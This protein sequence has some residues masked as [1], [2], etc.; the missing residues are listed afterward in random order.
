VAGRL[1]LPAASVLVVA[2][3]L[4][5]ACGGGSD[6]TTS[7]AAA[8]NFAPLASLGPLEPAPP[9]GKL[10]G[11]LV[12]I[13]NAP[14]LAPAASEAT[15]DKSVDGIK[16]EQNARLVFHVHTHITV[17]VDGKPRR[18]PAG[19]GIYPPI[20]P[21]NYRG[22]QFGLTAE[23]CITWLSTRYPDGLIHVESSEQRSF[24]LGD[25][26]KVWGQPL[27][28]DQVGPA[29]GDVTAIVNRKAWTGDPSEIKL[30]GHTQIQLMVG[31]PLIAPQTIRFPGL[32]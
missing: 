22:D 1:W 27:S 17:F 9:P 11:E 6:G 31:K 10:G 20:G 13:P 8:S 26:F 19:V 5:A 3:L 24:T 2:A 12:P 25:F 7:T 21:Q 23:N 18:I 30:A 14:E 4:C 16:C 28:T 32:F 15:T 29:K